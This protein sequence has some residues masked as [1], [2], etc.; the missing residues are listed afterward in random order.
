METFSDI[1]V[2]KYPIIL[3]PQF[4]TKYDVSLGG[5]T[6]RRRRICYGC[7]AE[8][9]IH[10]DLVF[11][12][13]THAIATFKYHRTNKLGINIIAVVSI[14]SENPRSVIMRRIA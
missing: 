5:N 11:I 9:L 2:E 3:R 13:S 1:S 4:G 14:N 7:R 12:L 6:F 8:R 10:R